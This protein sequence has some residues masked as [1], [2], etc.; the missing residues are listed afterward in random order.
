MWH[1]ILLQASGGQ[2]GL[3]GNLI[4]IGGI[5]L[6]FYFFMIRPQQKKQKDQKNFMESIKKGDTVVT[7]G[8]IH[9]KV[10]SIEKD[11]VVLDVDRG[12]KIKFDKS[13]ISLDSSKKAS[14][15]K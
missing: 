5:I 10:S 8:G 11:I 3:V 6:V 9:G 7:S 2:S 4:L 12:S 14:V 15:K 1:N 13:A